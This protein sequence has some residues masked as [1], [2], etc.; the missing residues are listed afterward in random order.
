VKGG[1]LGARGKKKAKTKAFYL[2]RG[3]LKEFTMR[4]VNIVVK[5]KKERRFSLVNAGRRKGRNRSHTGDAQSKKEGKQACPRE[6][7]TR[8]KKLN[9]V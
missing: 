8:K 1:G 2:R 7:F 5:G 6:K 4:K 3:N 9:S